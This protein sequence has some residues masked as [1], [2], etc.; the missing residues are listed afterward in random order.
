MSVYVLLC[1]CW[2]SLSVPGSISLSV[3]NAFGLSVSSKRVCYPAKTKKQ[4]TKKKRQEAF[5]APSDSQPATSL[6]TALQHTDSARLWSRSC[7]PSAGV[8][9]V[10]VDHPTRSTCKTKKR[11]REART[12]TVLFF[13][14]L[15]LFNLKKGEKRGKN[16]EQTAGGAISHIMLSEPES[17]T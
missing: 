5:S 3:Q 13:L 14:S 11:K 1:F 6:T 7:K 4:K 10:K 15:W 8:G 9:G 16:P 12:H 17:P 2:F